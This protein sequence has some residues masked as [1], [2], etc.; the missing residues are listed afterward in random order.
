MVI[1]LSLIKSCSLIDLSEES[2][3]LYQMASILMAM[4]QKFKSN[5]K[6]A[7]LCSGAAVRQRMSARLSL[8]CWHHYFGWHHRL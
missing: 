1:S 7:S 2:R 6:K 4:F 5:P 3:E 8:K